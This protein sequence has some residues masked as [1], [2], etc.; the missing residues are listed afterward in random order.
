MV[1]FENLAIDMLGPRRYDELPMSVYRD[2][3][4]ILE[5]GDKRWFVHYDGAVNVIANQAGHEPAYRDLLEQK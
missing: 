1:P 4:P 5:A 3:A 2:T